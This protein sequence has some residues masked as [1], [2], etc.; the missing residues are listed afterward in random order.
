MRKKKSGQEEEKE[1]RIKFV[2]E[3]EINGLEGRKKERKCAG[4]ASRVSLV[5]LLPDSF[6]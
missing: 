5:V 1:E 3:C 4:S 6:S 2:G